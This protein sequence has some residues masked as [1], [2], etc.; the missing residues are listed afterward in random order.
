MVPIFELLCETY[1]TESETRGGREGS[2]RG[3]GCNGRKGPG[4]VDLFM[5]GY[6]KDMRESGILGGIY[7]AIKEN[8]I[9]RLQGSESVSR[10]V[11][12]R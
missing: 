7:C 11:I 4:S 1:L 2:E 3:G 6:L 8:S 5:S 12:R 9:H 10:G